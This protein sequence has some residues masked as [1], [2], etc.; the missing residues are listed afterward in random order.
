[1]WHLAGCAV[2]AL[3]ALDQAGWSQSEAVLPVSSRGR[4][5]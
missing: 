4:C 3:N 2:P 1:V 5:F